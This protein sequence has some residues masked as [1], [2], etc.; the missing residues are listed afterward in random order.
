M[1]NILQHDDRV[2]HDHTDAQRNAAERHDIER[3]IQRIHQQEGEQDTARHRN[4]DRQRRTDI[5]QEHDQHDRRKQHA[6]PDIAHGVVDRHVDVIRLVH[7]QIPLQRA[8]IFGQRIELRLGALSDID[9]IR[10]GLLIDRQEQTFLAVDL[11][12]R[13]AVLGLHGYIRDLAQAHRAARGQRNQ[14][15]L[16]VV[17]RLILAVRTHRQCL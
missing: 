10:A 1:E 16:N 15:V 8:I 17:D 3:N 7:D 5:A 11:G 12:Q 6:H 2:I 4:R 14:C 13:V 9:R